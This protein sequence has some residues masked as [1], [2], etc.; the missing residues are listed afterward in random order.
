MNKIWKKAL[1]VCC[2]AMLTLPASMTVY[3]KTEVVAEAATSAFEKELSK[4]PSSY[5]PALRALHSKYPN[6]HFEA[7]NTGLNFETVVDNEMDPASGGNKST[8]WHTGGSWD[9][10]DLLKRNTA[11]D[12]NV[13]TGKYIYKDSSFVSAGRNTVAWFV[14][15]RNWLNEVDIFQFENK[16]Y[17][18]T[19][20]ESEL[21]S[22]VKAI[23]NGSFMQ[24]GKKISY[25]VYNSTTKKWST[26]TTSDT[27]PKV[28]LAAAKKYGMNPLYLA[29]KSIQEL[30][31]NGSD[32]VKG[33]HTMSSNKKVIKGLYNFF[34][35][36]ANDGS[37]PISNGLTFAA[38]FE[39]NQYGKVSVWDPAK[40][41]TS[42]FGRPWNTP[43]K[44]INGGAQFFYTKY[45]SAGQN[46]GYFVRFNVAPT[47]S[48]NRYWHQ[49][50][51]CISGACQEN[52]STYYAYKNIGILSKSRT[53]MI[54]VYQN[55]PSMSETISINGAS[56]TA[57]TTGSTNLRTGPGVSYNWAGSVAGGQKVTILEGVRTNTQYS[58]NSLFYPYWYKVRT[59]S[60]AVGYLCAE[61]VRPATSKKAVTGTK[62]NVTKSGSG[63]VYYYSDNPAVATI[64]DTGV[65][66]RKKNGKCNIYTFL[67]NGKF[68]VVQID[69]TVIANRVSVKTPAISS[70]T[71]D[72]W[73][74]TAKISWA[75]CS[76]ASGYEV[77]R[78]SQTDKSAKK[79]A[80]I[81]S[82][83][84]TSYTDK[85]LTAGGTYTY[86]V[87]AFKDKTYSAASAA[88]KITISKLSAAITSAQA[89]PQNSQ[90]TIKWNAVSGAT[91]YQIERKTGT[92]AY[93]CIKTVSSKNLGYTDSSV[94]VG[95]QYT[96]RIRAYKKEGTTN[97]YTG[98]SAAVTVSQSIQKPAIQKLST[99][100]KKNQIKIEWSKITFA[101]GYELYRRNYKT[102]TYK[103]IATLK[104]N[105]IVSYTD[106]KVQ[107]G[108]IYEYCLK[109]YKTINSK[110]VY[111]ANSAAKHIGAPMLNPSIKS[112][113]TNTTKKTATIKW[114][115]VAGA[116]G[117]R[118]YR[119]DGTAAT[120]CIKEIANNKTFT[121]VDTTIPVGIKS[122]YY[123]KSYYSGK[124]GRVY[125]TGAVGKTVTIPVPKP[126]LNSAKLNSKKQ[127]VLSWTPKTG[128]QGYSIWR[129][130]K[131]QSAYSW[132]ASS[133]G[134]TTKSYTDTK[135]KK[136]KTY[137]YIIK[138]Y[139][140]T[141][142]KTVY[143]ANSAM[144]RITV[145]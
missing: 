122:T 65:I 77:Y 139:V 86:T 114:S 93:K 85:N 26:K 67:S 38:G 73:A 107:R 5:Q 124:S 68:D 115:K 22:G 21:L 133:Y 142:G 127:V 66:T 96:Y 16:A 49:F 37:D 116:T 36:G 91:G 58:T 121:Y 28:F 59:A 128:V 143:S 30:G 144:K 71:A 103:K 130:E 47:N 19:M 55:M 48:A 102:G 92:G 14:D 33:T 20:S 61:Y 43:Q 100:T 75:K 18:S 141:G 2:S 44:A 4:F 89:I 106:T 9:S 45:V 70:V 31:V 69:T 29:S 40:W 64:S 42:T 6:W 98:Y 23:F 72:P 84:T 99:D 7:K 15:P 1:A 32:S 35:C 17:P 88:K 11:A 131:G 112:L 79:I 145:K 105:S 134:A 34:N 120:K 125:S 109:A 80:T 111:S 78:Q 108:Q 82:N 97:Y 74:K 135:V 3:Q 13:N 113:Q 12:Y 63:K 39:S 137:E 87:K 52:S 53:F 10:S 76:D 138:T 95:S 27:Y 129:R 8:V 117:Y 54:P 83:A 101:D 140:Y 104:K 62:I 41:Q 57:V 56:D 81:N 24:D 136:G 94:P 118:I 60:G 50:M 119:K 126:Q 132:I 51:T 123:V 25:Y 46:T 90:I 110:N